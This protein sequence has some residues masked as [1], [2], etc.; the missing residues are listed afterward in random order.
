MHPLG[1]W[2]P[3]S[4]WL[5]RKWVYHFSPLTGYIYHSDNH[6]YNV[7]SRCRCS[8]HQSQLYYATAE[9]VISRLPYDCIPVEELSSSGSFL[10]FRG[11]RVRRRRT[12]LPGPPV[13]FRE[14][15]SALPPWDRRLLQQVEVVDGAALIA[16]FLT[17]A[18]LYVVSDGGAD[19]DKGSYGAL[20]ASED[21]FFVKISGSTEGT[22][23]GSFR[24]ESYG[25]LAILRLVYHF[26][27]YHQLDP[28][29]C[30]NSFYCDNKGL[31]S[32]LAFAAGP[33]SPFPRHFLRSDM[34]LEMQI[35]DT[36]RLLGI[37]FTYTHVKGHQDT[38]IQSPSLA[39]PL[40]RQAELN[41][42]CDRL[43]TT[44]LQAAGPS[45]VV[46]FL[47][48]SRVTVTIDG[49]MVNHKLPR[50]IR[51][52]I[53]RRLQL[54]SFYRRYGWS[55]AQFAQINWPQYRSASAKLSLKKRLFTIKWLNDLLPFQVR[56][57]KYGQAPLA[58][59]PEECGCDSENQQHLLHCPAI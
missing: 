22:L 18:N 17:G 39:T 43:A 24:A 8:R 21:I 10:A 4:D 13:S 30:Q 2:L 6:T 16:Y 51:N 27:L 33:L 5:F 50:A 34:D 15:I 28:I 25:C 26:H 23:P 20:L 37:A 9:D 1:A 47:P 41:I 48:A 52:L 11:M 56:M 57:H 45:P 32:R 12:T 19:D 46:T 59:C 44:A 58:G 35:V 29:L 7:H 53:D 14:Y 42:E 31:I 49:T 3:G 38:A 54:S 40:T 55:E 36:I